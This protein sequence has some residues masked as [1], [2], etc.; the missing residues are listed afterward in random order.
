[1]QSLTLRRAT[2]DDKYL[3][4]RWANDETVR[5]YAFNKDFFS[6]NQ[7]NHWFN[8]V[9]K[10]DNV[11]IYVMFDEDVPIGQVR[12]QFDG[13]VYLIDYRIDAEHRGYGYGKV[14]L[15]LV[16]RQLCD[17]DLLL[18]QVVD[19]NELSC[20]I[21]QSLG[22]M[23][24]RNDKFKCMDYYKRIKNKYKNESFVNAHMNLRGGRIYN[25]LI[26]VVPYVK[27]STLHEVKV[28]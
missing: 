3:L 22:Y 21:F 6:S 1:M 17:G 2:L 28:A 27:K 23:A 11:F 14:I 13:D 10:S 8:N 26:S 15:Q 18:G 7:H 12:L 5:K 25:C 20:H 16:E 19:G 9:L 24:R 4:Y